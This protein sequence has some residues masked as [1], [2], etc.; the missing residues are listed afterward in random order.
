LKWTLGVGKY[1]LNAAVWGDTGRYPLS[2]EL[3]QQVYSYF[4]RLDQLDVEDSQTLVRHAFADQKTMKLSWY[5]NLTK[6]QSKTE[7]LTGKQAANP[8]ATRLAMRSLLLTQWDHERNQNRKLGFYNTIKT[9]LMCESYL[10]ANLSHRQSKRV[11]QIRT[12]AHRFNIETGRYATKQST[13]LSRVCQPCC[14]MESIGYLAELPLFE[15]I[16]EDELHVLQICP[17]Y[18]DLRSSMSR[19]ARDLLSNDLIQLFTERTFVLP[20]SKLLT[21]MQQRR[22]PPK[23]QEVDIIKYETKF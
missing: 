19:H 23:K 20:L 2:I 13:I 4:K 15:P 5:S 8:L 1:T 21:K 7:T 16:Y 22:F 12:S 14:D 10:S 17:L 18:E 9:S 3:T 11:A 6:A